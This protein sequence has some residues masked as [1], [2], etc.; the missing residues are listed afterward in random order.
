M[1]FGVIKI[2]K[3]ICCPFFVMDFASFVKL[4]K[5][6]IYTKILLLSKIDLYWF[7][8]IPTRN[9]GQSGEKCLVNKG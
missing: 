7:M 9:T 3:E 2:R 5:R 6:N 4:D 8:S 1:D